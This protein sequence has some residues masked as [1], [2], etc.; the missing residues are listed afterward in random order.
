MKMTIEKKVKIK[1]ICDI[2]DI[3]ITKKE[4]IK[5]SIHIIITFMICSFWEIPINLSEESIN[6][7]ACKRCVKSFEKWRKWRKCLE[8]RRINNH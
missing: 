4:K 7:H 1:I 3:E 8:K 2:C 6:Y 5:K